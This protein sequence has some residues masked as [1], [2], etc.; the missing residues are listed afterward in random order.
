MQVLVISLSTELLEG[1]GMETRTPAAP[2]G[3]RVL[4]QPGMAW[5]L[6][7]ANWILTVLDH[8]QSAIKSRGCPSL[9]LPTRFTPFNSKFRFDP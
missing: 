9:T 1:P 6:D 4:C 2:Q 5:I 3:W 7:V 8:E